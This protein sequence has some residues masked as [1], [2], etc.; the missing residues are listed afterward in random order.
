MFSQLSEIVREF[1]TTN[2][3]L[4]TGTPLQNNLHELWALLNFLLPD[5]F[6]SSEVPVLSFIL[7][8]ELWHKHLLWR[9][10]KLLKFPF[11]SWTCYECLLS[12]PFVQDFDSWFDTNNCLGDTKLV[13]RLHTVSTFSFDYYVDIYSLNQWLNVMETLKCILGS[14]ENDNIFG[15]YIV[16]F[17]LR[18]IS[19][20]S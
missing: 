5:V 17:G 9:V 7:P 16:Y 6:N 4:L 20:W 1:K 12:F 13:E 11:C 3:L 10:C 2:R 14:K 19:I 8:Q 15:K 18:N